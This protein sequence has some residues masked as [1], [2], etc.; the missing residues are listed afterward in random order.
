MVCNFAQP[1]K[2]ASPIMRNELGKSVEDEHDAQSD[3]LMVDKL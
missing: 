3:N 2:A 1:L